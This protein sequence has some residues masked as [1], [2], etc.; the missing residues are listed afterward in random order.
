MKIR[1]QIKKLLLYIPFILISF[2]AESHTKSE[3]YSNWIIGKSNVISVITIPLHE[4]TRVPYAENKNITFEEA[5][6]IHANESISV[7]NNDEPCNL[8][9]SQ[10]LNAMDGF[11]RLELIFGCQPK[12][13]M[14]INYRAIFE[15]SP[16]HTHYAKVYKDDILMSELLV[17]N[18]TNIWQIDTSQ[19]L[20]ENKNIVSFFVLGI[21][22]IIGGY[23]HLAF[24]F[25]VLLV[26]G[27]M[28]R[29]VIAVTGFTIGHS[30]SLI[31]STL[32]LI[33]ANSQV[34]EVFIGFTIALIAIEYVI[35]KIPKIESSII[36][37]FSLILFIMPLLGL[38][39]GSI[40]LK[41][42]L[43]YFGICLFTYCYLHTGK[44]LR[45][46]KTNTKN[47]LLLSM[48]IIF[49]FIHGLGF[50]GF[51]R[52]SGVVGNNII[53]PLLSFNLGLE[54][55]QIGIIILVWL[56]FKKTKHIINEPIPAISSGALFGIGF[57]WMI[58]RTFG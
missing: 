9:N 40:P 35:T 2:N 1:A 16:S 22:H 47:Y 14:K 30:L 6:Q 41:I 58:M 12:S 42:S 32:G 44:I 24:L 39:F 34:V 33:E 29:C 28:R 17:N 51:L 50:A 7:F 11:V 25:G 19:Q 57:Y 55:G 43:G 4:V 18:A 48:T 46:T 54:F 21:N 23:D 13:I 3:S 56:I 26:A 49:G 15:F 37:N 36:N 38:I 8:D 53:A 5:F 20:K 52:D 31:G 10:V 27:S 45:H